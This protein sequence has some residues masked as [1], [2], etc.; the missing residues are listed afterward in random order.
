MNNTK[1]LWID[2]IEV[3]KLQFQQLI[4]RS[5]RVSC[6]SKILYLNEYN[7]H[8]DRNRLIK[9]PGY[10]ILLEDIH[11]ISF[12]CEQGIILEGEYKDR[13]IKIAFQ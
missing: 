1:P 2:Q 9:S 5:H 10:E 13:K 11:S 3:F 6:D 4:Q 7:I 8:E 12:K